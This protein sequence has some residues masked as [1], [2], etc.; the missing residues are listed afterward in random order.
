MGF[1]PPPWIGRYPSGFGHLE[2][3]PLAALGALTP[4]NPLA[5]A[6][7]GYS[8]SP[9]TLLG[10]PPPSTLLG[11][12]SPTYLWAYVR[13]R[14]GRFLANLA[15]TDLQREDALTKAAGI[16][17]C[18]NRWYW[19][20]NSETANGMVIGSWGKST[21]VRPPRDIDL[22]FLLPHDVY[23]QFAARS[24]NR[25]SQLLQDVRGALAETY[26][27]TEMRADGQVV[28]VPFNTTAVEIAPGFRCV[29]GSIILCDANDGGRYTTSTAEAELAGLNTSDTVYLGNTRA[30]V[31]M[32]KAWQRERNVPLKSFQ[33]ERLAIEFLWRWPYSLRD[34]FYYDWMIR[35]FL[36]HLIGRANGYLAMPGTGEI[37]LLGSDW[38][39]KA[40][41]AY[42]HAV[43]A[44]EH[45]R[46][47]YEALAG[48]EWQAIFGSMIP[49]LVS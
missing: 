26:P 4:S 19:G 22:L 44:C 32:L 15:I 37:V 8:F 17:S 41:T 43:T 25:Q 31:R 10:V 49:V 14:F 7:S 42:R 18:L 48:Q 5:A 46:D 3:N 16:R 12:P 28:V 33:L 21:Q 34:V 30:L 11:A 45:E 23:W 38:L 1:L 29:D 40:V 2:V 20:R 27:Q 13:Q 6:L 36:A 9:S 35:D 39:S 47:N 24:G